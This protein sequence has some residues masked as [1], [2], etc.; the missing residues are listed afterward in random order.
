MKCVVGVVLCFL[1][2]VVLCSSNTLD[3]MEKVGKNK[4]E[5]NIDRLIPNLEKLIFNS[6]SHC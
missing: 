2:C 3:E 5:N 4:Q 6:A 1:Y